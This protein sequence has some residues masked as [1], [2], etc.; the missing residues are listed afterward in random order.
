MFDYII[1]GAGSAGCVLANRL[2]ANS[3]NKVL[4]IEAGPADKSPML[5]MPG[6]TAEAIKS[7]VLNWKF[8]SQP[9]R[10]MND[11]EIP[12]PRGRTLGGC[13]AI[14]GMAYVRGHATDYD[15][16]AAAGNSGWSYD[17]VLP[18]FKKSENN[19]RG[20]SKYH[21]TGGELSVNN[22]GSGLE[23]FQR[24]LQA[25]QRAGFD[26]NEDFNGERQDGVGLFQVTIN[27][28]KRCSTA[29]AFLKPV[30]NRKNL[31]VMTDTQVGKL[32]LEGNRVTGVEVL[33]NG[34]R[35]QLQASKEV[36]LSAGSI[37]SPHIMQLSGIGREEDLSNAGITQTIELPGVGHNLQ[38][39]LDLKLNWAI[40]EPIALNKLV[41]FPH[42]V[43]VGL[44]YVFR[45]KGIAANSGI[46]GCAF[47]RSDESLHR[48]DVQFHFVPA[49]M[50]F[51][52]D[53]LPEQHGVTLRACN[54][55]PE[56][57][58]S[59]LAS[60]DDPSVAPMIDFN[61]MSND[62]DKNMM[63]KALYKSREIMHT[64]HWEGL[65][66][67]PLTKGLDSDDEDVLLEMIKDTSDTVY[68]PVGT[69]KMGNDDQAV[70]DSQLR[71]HGVEGLRVADASIIPT[72]IGGNTNAPVI[73]IAEKCADMILQG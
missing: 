27:K 13:S 9:Q 20:E 70:V 52:T 47:W 38:E 46:E 64:D 28:G 53:P 25:L 68:H 43:M 61:F 49:Y 18:Y 36:V 16:W 3:E 24:W 15:D 67:A 51:L 65:I 11:R 34:G 30:R 62:F 37:G 7:D 33:R 21:G 4:L 26:Y 10:F 56:A 57:R 71:V 58:G 32:L 50:H 6:G 59:V 29:S 2:S 31:S 69:C 44:N 35:E 19:V 42:N 12:V 66:E 48:P 8:N 73:M 5:H 40:N 17:E 72:M 39:H 45:K 1:V 54:L 41:R 23:L 55:R 63:L 14:N 22:A 60:C